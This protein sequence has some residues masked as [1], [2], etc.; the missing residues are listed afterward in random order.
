MK[1]LV[2]PILA[3]CF[4]FAFL[5]GCAGGSQTSYDGLVK[6]QNTRMDEVW[7][8][9][10]FDPNRYSKIIFQGAGI[11]YVPPDYEA[12]SYWTRD[13]KAGYGM[14]QSQ[15]ERL[16]RIVRA[17]FGA[18]LAKVK[19]FEVVQVADPET[20]IMNIAL[21]DVIS[22]VPPEEVGAQHEVY[23]AKVGSAT[24]AVSFQDAVSG[25]IMARAV[26]RKAAELYGGEFGP[27]SNVKNWTAVT[28]L[29]SVWAR[30]LRRALDELKTAGLPAQ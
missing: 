27:S 10:G 13:W 4:A 9:P 14:N 24:L 8:R 23:L 11:D 19:E 1:Q 25:A 17:E 30:G 7:V 18:E 20:L 29:A 15:R 16:Q 6:L 21:L 26:D 3:A 28:E 12:G 22:N 2:N 5:S